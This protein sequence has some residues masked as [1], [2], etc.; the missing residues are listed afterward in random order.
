MDASPLD[1]QLKAQTWLSE[2]KKWNEVQL[3]SA[4]VR[5]QKWKHPDFGWIK[6]NF[7]AAWMIMVRMG[8]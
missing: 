2:F 7:D 5:V 3:H 8:I 1:V 6:C 4:T